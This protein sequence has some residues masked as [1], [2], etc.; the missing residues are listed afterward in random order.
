MYIRILS[1]RKHKTI[2]FING[3]NNM[4]GN[5]QYMI[6]ND[7]VGSMKCGDLI[8]VECNET[9]NNKGIPIKRI[10]KILELIPCDNFESYKGINNELN[11]QK[12]KNF[13]EARNG[14]M[15]IQVL[16][17]KRDIICNIKEILDSLNFI[18]ASCLTKVVENYANGSGIID[19]IIQNREYNDPKY[20]RV[21]LENQLKQMTAITLQSTY[22]IEKVFRNMGEDN[23]HI[24]EFL[25][26]ELVSLSKDVYQLLNFIEKIDLLSKELGEKHK[27]FIPDKELEIID[28][29]DL[30][31][32]NIDYEKLKMNFQNTLVLNY[33]CSSPFIKKDVNDNLRKEIRWYMNGHWICHFYQD[34]NCFENIKEILKIQNDKSQKEDVNPL[35]YFEWGLPSTTSL[36]LSIDRWLQMLLDFDNINTIANPIG[37]DYTKKITRR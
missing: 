1:I 35:K 24:N 19:A 21:T 31:K 12:Y 27:L 16:N 18:D 23:S 14:G 32:I 34:E 7:I 5:N 3:Y 29:N 22:A 8:E 33:P 20:L 4:Y 6:D 11:D 10:V 28:Y 2:T 30:F 36:G 15:Q 9:I 25:M 26:L 13:I 37:L 17:Y